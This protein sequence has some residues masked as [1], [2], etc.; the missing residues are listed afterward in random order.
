MRIGVFD[1]YFFV[2]YPVMPLIKYVIRIPS[3]RDI[4]AFK[5]GVAGN[6]QDTLAEK[7]R[8]ARRR[9]WVTAPGESVMALRSALWSASGL[10][11]A[12]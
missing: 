4:F 11:R 12:S 3:R 9:L 1:R 8:G 2:R 7:G 5:A 6:M 10:L